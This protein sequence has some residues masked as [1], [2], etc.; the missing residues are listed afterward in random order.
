M[1]LYPQT[2]RKPLTNKFIVVNFSDEG[3]A[4]KGTQALDAFHAEGAFRSTAWACW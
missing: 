4:Y 2:R 3:T 1:A